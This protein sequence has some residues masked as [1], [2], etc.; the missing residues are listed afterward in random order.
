MGKS[1]QTEIGLGLSSTCSR[2]LKVLP[3]RVRK[4][5]QQLSLILSS[6]HRPKLKINRENNSQRAKTFWKN[7]LAARDKGV[8]VLH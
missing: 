5:R 8:L 6:S 4:H 1:T 2:F 7:E 3:F